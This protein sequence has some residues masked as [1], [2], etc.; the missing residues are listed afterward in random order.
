MQE[1]EP[2]SVEQ[3]SCEDPSNGSPSHE[4]EEDLEFGNQELGDGDMSAEE[5]PNRQDQ[6]SDLDYNLKCSN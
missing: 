2:D 6:M 5:G 3:G 1:E 4:D